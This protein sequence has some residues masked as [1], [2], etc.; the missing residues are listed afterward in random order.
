V[1]GSYCFTVRATIGLLVCL[2][3]LS[4]CHVD[5]AGFGPT[6]GEEAPAPTGESPPKAAPAPPPAPA[7]T[8]GPQARPV[9]AA[10][11]PPLPADAGP[12]DTSPADA[13]MG[14]VAPLT[15]CYNGMICV[16]LLTDVRNCGA[17]GNACRGNKSCVRGS[18]DNS[19][20]G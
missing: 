1:S 6:A 7:S 17:C 19:G 13:Q 2:G 10:P 3:W 8:P 16:D 11:S 9:D 4:G 12:A 15:S 18:C 5:P 20:P 14:C